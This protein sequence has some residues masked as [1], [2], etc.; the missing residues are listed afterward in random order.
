MTGRHVG[1]AMARRAGCSTIQMVSRWLNGRHVFPSV[2]AQ[3]WGMRVQQAATAGQSVCPSA[4]VLNQ[5]VQKRTSRGQKA[6]QQS[7]QKQHDNGSGRD[8]YGLH[9]LG[10]SAS[11]RACDAAETAHTREVG[12]RP[13]KSVLSIPR[14][15]LPYVFVPLHR[16]PHSPTE[17]VARCAQRA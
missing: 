15:G 4:V 16:L 2:T 11:N 3:R 5:D 7:L 1:A 12:Y 8:D 14:P 10:R 6:A 13:V 17:D 9:R